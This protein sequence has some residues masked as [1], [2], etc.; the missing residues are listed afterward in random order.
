MRSLMCSV[1]RAQPKIVDSVIPLPA[2][3]VVHDL[4]ASQGAANVALHDLPMLG[5]AARSS[6]G[7]VNGNDAIASM[8]FEAALPLPESQAD[9]SHSNDARL[10]AN[11]SAN[12]DTGSDTESSPNNF[13]LL[14]SE[15]LGSEASKAK[16]L[17]AI[18]D[19]PLATAN[20]SSKFSARC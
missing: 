13:I 12:I 6:V 8:I 16:S 18:V 7:V 15:R 5:N 3:D 11:L 14:R 4:I 19:G 10:S 20:V 1:A 17:E 2:V 9:G